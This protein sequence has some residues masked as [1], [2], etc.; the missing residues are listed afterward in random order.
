VLEVA[1]G[2][3]VIRV[4][5]DD[6]SG[7]R[8]SRRIRGTFASGETRRLDASVGGVIQKDLTLVWGP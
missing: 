7:F 2:E 5:V 1:P 8:E 3:R 4:Q 6:G